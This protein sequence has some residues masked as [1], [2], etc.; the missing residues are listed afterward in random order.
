MSICYAKQFLWVVLILSLFD[1]LICST[2]AQS[3]PTTNQGVVSVSGDNNGNIANVVNSPNAQITQMINGHT[4]TRHSI[5]SLFDA[6]NPDVLKS[7]D[8]GTHRV[9]VMIG[10]SHLAR[11][12]ELAENDPDFTNYLI[13]QETGNIMNGTQ[14]SHMGDFLNDLT[15]TSIMTGCVVNF[16][17][18]I[19]IP[20]RNDPMTGFLIPANDP[21]P[22]LPNGWPAP[23]NF[24]TLY[25]GNSASVNCWLPHTVINFHGQPILAINTNSAGLYVSAKIYGENGNMVCMLESNR[26]TI[27]PSNF[28]TRLMPDKSTLIVHDRSD[29]EVLN[30]RYLNPHAISLNCRL[31]LPDGREIVISPTEGDFSH[32]LVT[33]MC[34]YDVNIP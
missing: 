22:S 31:K 24:I 34:F 6:I 7:V 33:A 15:D 18:A 2:D 30:M 8:A 13:F 3:S 10:Q 26:F 4:D 29:V 25:L 16:N 21:S 12:Y 9:D 27:N 17:D 19:K 28:L 1:F 32:H 5:R 23:T 20:L 14:N 11:L